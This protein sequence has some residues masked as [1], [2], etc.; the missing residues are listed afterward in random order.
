MTP[1]FLFLILLLLFF[2]A[3]GGK[4]SREDERFVLYRLGRL[5]GLRGPGILFI[6]PAVDKGLKIREGDRGEL[7]G[8]ESARMKV[9]P[10]P[11]RVEG[12]ARTGQAVRI[13]GFTSEYAVVEADHS[14]GREFVCAKCGHINRL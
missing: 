4:V 14:Q 13:G 12:P 7:L 11:V 3:S 8:P 9:L 6:R 5:V 1:G 2:L 10:I